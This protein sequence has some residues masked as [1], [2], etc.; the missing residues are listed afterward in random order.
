MYS[1][2][3]GLS[4]RLDIVLQAASNLRHRDDIVFVFVGDGATRESVECSASEM[5][6][7]NVRFLA[8]S[9]RRPCPEPKHGRPAVRAAV[10]ALTKYLMPSKLYSALAAGS[11]VV[12]I[13]DPACELR[14]SWMKRLLAL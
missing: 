6:L 8:T 9:P 3:M 2:N 10:S 11:F 13:T 14:G 5:R 1:G 7:P 4:Q 12:A